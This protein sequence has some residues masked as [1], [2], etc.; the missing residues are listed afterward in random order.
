MSE[1]SDSVRRLTALYRLLLRLYSAY[2]REAYGADMVRVFGARSLRALDER[3]RTGLAL[4]VCRATLDV[5][6]NAPQERWSTWRRERRSATGPRASH[7]TRTTPPDGDPVM[8]RLLHD[9]RFAWRQLAR[10][11]GLTATLVATLALGTGATTALFSI[12]DAA[13]LRPLPYPADDRLVILQQSNAEF[14]TFGFAPPYLADLR[15]RID[16]VRPLAGFSPSWEM[17]LTE[18][19]EPRTVVAAFVTDGLLELFGATPLQGRLFDASEHGPGGP[20][21]AVVTRSFW[22]RSFG[23]DARLSGQS[24]V[25]DGSS[26]PIVGV[27]EDVPMPVTASLVSQDG[28]VASVWLPFAAN[29]YA[30]LRAIPVMNVVG[31]LDDDVPLERVAATLESVAAGL[32]RD[33]PESSSGVALSASWLRDVVTTDARRTVLTLFGAAAL[34]LL[35]ACVNVANL[36]LA[37]ATVRGQEIAVRRTVG[38]GPGQIVRQLLAESVLLAALG[39]TVGLVLGA[40]VTTSVVGAGL[41]GLPP[42]AEVRFDLRVAAFTTALA[43]LTALVFGLVPA[44]HAARR[45]PADLL[46]SGGRATGGG[47][48]LR[49]ALVSAEVALAVTLLVGAGLLGRSFWALV[50]VDPGFRAEGL[51]K[52]PV[53]VAASGRGTFES[54]RAFLDPLL[55]DLGRLPGVSQIAAVNRLPLEGGNVFVSIELE[56]VETSADGLPSVDR[57]V[58][59][60]GYFD[61]MGTPIVEGRD[62]G[63]DDQPESPVRA[64]VVNE[65]FARRFWPQGTALNRRLRL[66]LRSGPGPWLT[67]VGV[68][69]DVRHHGLGSSPQPEVYVPYAQASVESMVLVLRTDG[70]PGALTRAARDVVWRHDADLP[71]DD[72]GTVESVVGASVAEPRLRALVLNG[73]AALA[74]ALAAVGIYGV[75]SYSVEQRRRETGMRIALGARPDEVLRRIVAEGLGFAA[76]GALVGLAGAWALGRAVSSLLFD[77]GSTDPL[78]FATVCALM[79]LVAALASLVPAR[80][81]ARVDPVEALRGD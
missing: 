30:E 67:V 46:R 37:R 18:L 49:G 24:L 33:Y 72:V 15:E 8:S 44:V 66:M 52:V 77:V 26:F 48:R 74:L 25:L 35:I 1:R 13:L 60:P 29:P 70:D 57:R 56:G 36:L 68:A 32:A 55:D 17:S 16:G 64:A 45:D 5:A 79:L 19:G 9:L 34:L 22:E 47:N 53:S 69:G 75:I 12:V 14:G 6:W 31:S 28:D 61:L 40:F 62:F 38:A 21:A 71:L 41:A 59:T 4:W 39:C 80:R 51:L 78:T 23:P 63:L 7:A 3:G 58:A 11:K 43:A 42:W 81:A 20:P 50:N 76:W 73:F 65:T 2:F 27:A 10:R 54:R